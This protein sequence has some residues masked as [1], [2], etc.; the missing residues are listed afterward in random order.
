MTGQDVVGF[1]ADIW[2]D[3]THLASANVLSLGFRVFLL[4]GVTLVLITV[5]KGLWFTLWR[6]LLGPISDAVL[7]L[8]ERPFRAYAERKRRERN[9]RER[10]EF[11]RRLEAETRERHARDAA[12]RA[13]QARRAE[14]VK[15]KLDEL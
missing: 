12:E 9:R 13:E 7:T 6:Q 14:E 2:Y 5:V 11:H 15:R 3:L 10:E 8:I 1:L 4:I